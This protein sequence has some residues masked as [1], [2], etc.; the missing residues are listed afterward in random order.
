V[1]FGADE[2]YPFDAFFE[3]LPAL[4]ANQPRLYLAFGRN[5]AFEGRVTAA[6]EA[7]KDE[8]RKGISGPWDIS[9]PR[10]I[11]WDMRLVKD[12]SE[13]DALQH[14][15]DVTSAGVIAAMKAVRPNMMEYELAGVLEF[16]FRRRGASR[17]SFDTICAAGANAATL[18]YTRNDCRIGANDMVL[19][20]TG[21][22]LGDMSADVS[23]TFPANG[24]FSEAGRAV[25][26]WV[27]RAHKAATSAVR[28]GATY[29]SVQDAAVAVLCEG[30]IKL[31]V[32]KGTVQQAMEDA[33]YKPY[34]MHRIGHWL[35][36]DVHDVGPYYE[37]GKS[38]RLR[39][40]MVMTIEPGLYFARSLPAPEALKG[41]GVRIED[42]V[43]V[44]ASGNRIL[45]P[46]VP[47]EVDDIERLMADGG[48]WWRDVRPWSVKSE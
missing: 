23:R 21:C 12:Q 9:D 6:I 22:E 28:A 17:L 4:L 11:L 20:D 33:T 38:I 16:E 29:T 10:V 47:R 34:F 35:G 8:G 18:H 45:T 13:M 30:L 7:L 14:A 43:V 31:G 40:G 32:L 2:A 27:L 48:A 15:C 46:D 41:I 25:Y 19:V 37:G 44:T 26:E 42:D 39:A 24:R 3:H 36:S 1:H 5:V